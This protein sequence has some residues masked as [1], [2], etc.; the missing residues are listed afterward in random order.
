M[1]FDQFRR[2][3]FITL[4]GGAAVVCPLAAAERVRRIGPPATAASHKTIASQGNVKQYRSAGGHDAHP[5]MTAAIDNTT[6]TTISAQS[7][8]TMS[9]MR[10]LRPLIAPKHRLRRYRPV[11]SLGEGAMTE[12]PVSL[13]DE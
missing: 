8:S 3:D 10:S 11:R 12:F 1:Q 6:T 5:T 7:S 4:L 9:E 13:D 2:R